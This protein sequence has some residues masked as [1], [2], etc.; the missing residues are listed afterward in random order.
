MT[1]V[2]QILKDYS[3][4]RDGAR[5]F[6]LV[7]DELRRIADMRLRGER[8]GHTLQ[9]TALV[10]EA[11]L[12]LADEQQVDWASR[13]HFFFAAG[14]AMQQILVEHARGRGRQKRGGGARRVP[15]S[16]VDLASDNDADEILALDEAFCRLQ[17]ED[18][19]SADVV[20]LRFFAGLSVDETAAALQVSPRQVDRMWT[21]ARARLFQL[22]EGQPG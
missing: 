20:R 11:Y 19:E 2:T 8:V 5:L 21:F 16:V 6:A 17:A 12:R 10:N 3:A 22:M 13:A 15:L 1:E 4:E 14:R 9:A 18:R 7:H